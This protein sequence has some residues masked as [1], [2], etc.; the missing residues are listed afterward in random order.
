MRVHPAMSLAR[1]R[2][3]MGEASLLDAV[4]LRDVLLRRGVTDTD[5]LS[6]SE[7]SDAI[8]TAYRRL[9]KHLRPETA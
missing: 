2:H 3:A 9:P 5:D 7:W 6:E 1:L 4:A 8:R